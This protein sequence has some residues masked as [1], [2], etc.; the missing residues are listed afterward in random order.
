MVYEERNV[1]ATLIVT[2]VVVPGYIVVIL[3]QAADGPLVEVD[4]FPVML[5]AI[6]IS[7]A[8]AIVLGI[9]WG[10]LAARKDP[11]G[12]GRSDVRDR[13]I[14]RMGAR[15]EHAFLVIAGLV[16]IALCA[17]GADVFWIANTMF[18][19]F[20]VSAFIGGVARVVAYRRGLV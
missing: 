7:I 4:W 18:L 14:N 20:A 9:L 6:G 15:V 17:V 3:Q 12:A 19:G 13:D 2:A 16:V 11:D 10:L 1:W 5:W 8:A